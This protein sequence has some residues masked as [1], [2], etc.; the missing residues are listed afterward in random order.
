[1]RAA[2]DIA[3]LLS[4]LSADTVITCGA[5]MVVAALV[6]YLS[7]QANTTSAYESRRSIML[8]EA[9]RSEAAKRRRRSNARPPGRTGVVCPSHEWERRWWSDRFGIPPQT[10]AAL[11]HPVGPMASD[12]ERHLR[13]TRRAARRSPA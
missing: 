13:N 1:M 8:L 7:A 4:T 3:M 2:E 5:L 11:V 6:L 10:L 9:A 12:I